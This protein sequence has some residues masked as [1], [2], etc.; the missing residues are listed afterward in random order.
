MT[1]RA[2]SH[3]LSVVAG[4][5]L[6]LSMLA[7]VNGSVWAKVSVTRAVEYDIIVDPEIVSLARIKE[8]RQEGRV[9][10]AW[11]TIIPEKI[12]PDTEFGSSIIS[13]LRKITRR[14]SKIFRSGAE[15]NAAF[16]FEKHYIADVI[17]FSGARLKMTA[18][19]VNDPDYEELLRIKGFT[20]FGS[21][22]FKREG[23]TYTLWRWLKREADRYGYLGIV[24]AQFDLEAHPTGDSLTSEFRGNFER[25][26]RNEIS[27]TDFPE[28][29]VARE[30]A[31]KLYES[32]HQELRDNVRRVIEKLN[33]P[34]FLLSD[35]NVMSLAF[36]PAGET[37]TFNRSIEYDWF[38]EK[39]SVNIIVKGT[40]GE[41]YFEGMVETEPIEPYKDD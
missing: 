14:M 41:V 33:A 30:L 24:S 10:N 29:V 39:R 7:S 21:K 36:K 12:I 25:I 8:L 40:L 35:V 26:S 20:R 11:M 22:T 23:E 34:I 18:S 3:W 9:I 28:T 1:G 19:F 2:R 5:A 16:K 38:G 17:D 37:I 27:A 4:L 32:Y 15:Y 6:A 13:G 31:R